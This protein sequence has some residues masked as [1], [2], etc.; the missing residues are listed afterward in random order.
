MTSRTGRSRFPTF[1]LAALLL[2]AAP[3]A[4][5]AQLIYAPS[6]S[7]GYRGPS[8]G[9]GRMP[10]R[11][12]ERRPDRYPDRPDRG[13]RGPGS[14][15]ECGSDCHVSCPSQPQQEEPGSGNN[16]RETRR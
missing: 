5:G 4:A 2:A 15:N 8:D 11:V 10:G 6:Q 14:D 16:C 1:A 7:E 9:G 12:P 3:T 13:P